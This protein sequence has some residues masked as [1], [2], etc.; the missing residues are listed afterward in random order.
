LGSSPNINDPDN[1]RG[2]GGSGIAYVEENSKIM[3][4]DPENAKD[5]NKAYRKVSNWLE[6]IFSHYQLIKDMNLNLRNF[7]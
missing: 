3:D 2:S 7:S 5:F 1:I 4:M 6:L